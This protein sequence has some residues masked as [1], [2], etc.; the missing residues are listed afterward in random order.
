MLP[1]AYGTPVSLVA[2]QVVNVTESYNMANT[3]ME[4]INDL[5]VVCFVQDTVTKEIY[6]A[7]MSSQSTVGIRGLSSGLAIYPNPGYGLVKIE[8]AAGA[9]LRVFSAVGELVYEN[10]RFD[11][12]KVDLRHLPAGTYLLRIEEKSGLVSSHKL[13]LLD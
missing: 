7:A 12:N 10:A 2:G 6:Q 9:H 3:F 5:S 1:S 13:V 4:D 11:E 8:G